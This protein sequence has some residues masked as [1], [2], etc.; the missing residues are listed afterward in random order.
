MCKSLFHSFSKPR[1]LMTRFFA[2]PCMMK[3][4]FCEMSLSVSHFLSLSL[5]SL[6]PALPVLEEWPGGGEALEGHDGSPPHHCGPVAPSEGLKQPS[7]NSTLNCPSPQTNE[8]KSRVPPCGP[9]TQSICTRLSVC[10]AT[11]WVQI[12]IQHIPFSPSLHFLSFSLSSV[13]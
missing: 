12:A 9:S 13:S 7:L 1:G 10:L 8:K 5:S 4:R 3:E 2:T 6:W 11:T